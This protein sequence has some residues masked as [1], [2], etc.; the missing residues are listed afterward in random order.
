MKAKKDSGERAAVREPMVNRTGMDLSPHAADM[1]EGAKLMPP[2]SDG[3]EKAIASVLVEYG[4]EALPIGTMPPPGKRSKPPT[5]PAVLIDKLGER[6]A[7]ERTGVRLYE[8]LIAKFDALGGYP[9]GPTRDDLVHHRDEEAA[10]FLL[11]AE[12]LEKLGGDPT[13]QTP[14]AD[15]HGVASCGIGQVVCD[16]RTSLP[17]ALE[18]MMVAELTD[19]DA[20]KMLIEL[21]GDL[22]D[23]TIPVAEF[24]RARDAEQEHL[25]DTRRW[26]KAA[27]RVR[28]GITAVAAE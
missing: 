3:D 22:P 15:V 20:W 2:S 18:A 19:F 11:V 6:L 10:H 23:N 13:A 12:T 16:P 1:L 9:D 8:A 21:A 28:A 7:F 17:Q 24:E 5:A 14:A 4:E 27:L 25:A 26:V